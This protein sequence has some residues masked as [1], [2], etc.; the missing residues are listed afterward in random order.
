MPYLR[1]DCCIC[2]ASWNYSDLRRELHYTA[3]VS[4]QGCV[5]PRCGSVGLIASG[6]GYGANVEHAENRATDNPRN[7]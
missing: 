6:V 4:V 5:C 1:V 2:G 3:A 7:L